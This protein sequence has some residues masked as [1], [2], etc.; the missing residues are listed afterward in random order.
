MNKLPVAPQTNFIAMSQEIPSTK[1]S[2][3]CG[4]GTTVVTNEYRIMHIPGFTKGNPPNKKLKFSHPS[5]Q[6]NISLTLR[7]P[8]Q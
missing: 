1:I 7:T 3:P 2:I 5:N 8:I 4:N 6:T